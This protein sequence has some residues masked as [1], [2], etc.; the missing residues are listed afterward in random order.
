[1][2]VRP[3]TTVLHP[4]VPSLVGSDVT[5][6]LLPNGFHAVPHSLDPT[7]VCQLSYRTFVIR[8]AQYCTEV[9][10]ISRM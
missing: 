9:W 6:Q 10:L 8:T 1:V 7:K 5:G 2:S 4:S 3:T